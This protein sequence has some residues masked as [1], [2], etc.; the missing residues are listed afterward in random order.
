MNGQYAHKEILKIISHPGNTIE[1]QMRYY[2]TPIERLKLK[3]YNI[4]S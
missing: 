1:N 2:Y 3:T 4:N